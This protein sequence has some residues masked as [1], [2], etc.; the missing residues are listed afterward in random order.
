METIPPPTAEESLT[1]ERVVSLAAE[2]NE[3]A[4][5][6]QARQEAA[7]AR[8]ARARAFFLPSLTVTGSY[9][10]QKETRWQRQNVLGGQGIARITLF[11]ARGIPLHQAAKRES[12]AT[13]LDALE[14]R[15]QLSFQAAE[16]FLS[17]LSAQHVAEVSERR[18]TLA[19]QALAESRTRTQKGLVNPKTVTRA[20]LEVANAETQLAQ[21]RGQ[22]QTSRLELGYLLVMPVEG[23]L[24]EPE[25][26][27]TEASHLPWTPSRSSPRTP[28]SAARTSSPR[29][30]R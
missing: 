2:R 22:F 6:A 24:A 4:L 16:A 23:P 1:L 8:V 5:S 13:A 17:T 11:S 30:C 18:L 21:A 29:G 9:T 15:R 19:R 26:L 20:E 25:T 7:E 10:H 28:G 14:T 3:T 27:L 12:E